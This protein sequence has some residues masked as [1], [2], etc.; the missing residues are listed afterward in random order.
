MLH[1]GEAY[2]KKKKK[3]SEYKRNTRDVAAINTP[4]EEG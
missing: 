1:H 4:H 3:E 2:D